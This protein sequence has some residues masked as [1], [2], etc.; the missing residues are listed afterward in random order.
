MQLFRQDRQDK[1]DFTTE[2]QPPAQRAYGPE[3]EHREIF[4]TQINADEHGFAQEE[5]E[6]VGMD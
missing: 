6:C 4:W 5:M 1:Q 2:P 3:G